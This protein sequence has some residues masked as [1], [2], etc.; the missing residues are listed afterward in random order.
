M[1]WLNF[2]FDGLEQKG[3]LWVLVQL[4]QLN[5]QKGLGLDLE[6]LNLLLPLFLLGEVVVR[7]WI[8]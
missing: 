7:S 4:S 8:G 1:S 2:P 5:R 3:L 6:L